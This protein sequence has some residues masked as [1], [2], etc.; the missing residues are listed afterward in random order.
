MTNRSHH[1]CTME[2]VC[3]ATFRVT[4]KIR[5]KNYIDKGLVTPL[6]LAQLLPSEANLHVEMT[7]PH[8]CWLSFQKPDMKESL[9]SG[10]YV[11]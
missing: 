5:K 2:C 7:T 1:A 10:S 3:E 8:L 6:L 11:L 4:N 9:S